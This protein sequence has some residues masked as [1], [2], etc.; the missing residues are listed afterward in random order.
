MSEEL[1]IG[2]I[3][4][5]VDY[6]RLSLPTN[7]PDYEF[8]RDAF[9][10]KELKEAENEEEP[11]EFYLNYYKMVGH[12]SV[13]HGVLNKRGLFQCAGPIAHEL[14]EDTKDNEFSGRCTRADTKQTVQYPADSTR[15]TL[16][17]LQTSNWKRETQ[18][19]LHANYS[20]LYSGTGSGDT[21][22]FGRRSAASFT[23]AY[24]AYLRHPERYPK[25]TLSFE[26]QHNTQTA[27]QAWNMLRAS[28]H[29]SYAAGSLTVGKL[30]S[31]G[32]NEFWAS[33]IPPTK[34]PQIKHISKKETTLAHVRRCQR[35]QFTRAR[36]EGWHLEYL[37]ELGFDALS[38]D[39]ARDIFQLLEARLSLPQEWERGYK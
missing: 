7:A 16:R 28:S 30:H 10:A 8:W 24:Q 25:D 4:S 6:V 37:R 19:G 38:D 32:V 17:R 18:G 11:V 39:Q 5:C 29:L 35:G 21:I 2:I 15:E 20:A 26:V 23:R 13:S 1:Y 27:P 14:M 22:Y 3:E 33:D 31:I 9:R 36:R 12:G 34:A